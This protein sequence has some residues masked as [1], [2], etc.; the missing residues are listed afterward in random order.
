MSAQSLGMVGLWS[1]AIGSGVMA[2]IYFTFSS[3]VMRSLEKLPRADGVAAMQSINR[4]IL[5][6]SFM[7]L[8]VGSTVLSASLAVWSLFRW[9]QH[10]SWAMLAG[11]MIYVL[12]MF[13]CTAA[14][15][16]PLNN[17]LDAVDPS[18]AEAGMVWSDYLHRW[19][20]FNHLRTVASALACGLFIAA[21]TA[22]KT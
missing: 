8:F 4:V 5:S 6:S 9:G 14:F 13:V 1:A 15:N 17:T 7:P 21:V 2:G 18:S 16:V 12:G 20:R 11:G 19:T 10:G 22:M 3:F